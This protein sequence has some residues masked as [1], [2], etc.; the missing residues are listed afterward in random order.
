MNRKILVCFFLLIHIVFAHAQVKISG[1]VV[2]K[3]NKQPLPYV[4]VVIGLTGSGL[5]NQFT[6][7]DTEGSFMMQL[8]EKKAKDFTLFCSL[9][10]YKSFQ[11][12][13][14]GT[15]HHYAIEMV[16]VATKIKEVTVRAQKI[17]EHGDTITYNVESFRKIQDKT[18]GDVLQKMPGIE[19]ASSG[20]ISYNG[21]EINKFYIEG[22]DLL[23]GKYGI[24]TN[25][26]SPDDVGSVEILENHQPIKALQNISISS[27]TAINLRLK[28]KAKAKWVVN[29]LGSSGFSTQPDNGLWTAEMF[30]MMIKANLQNITIL[31]SNNIGKDL[32]HELTDFNTNDNSADF[33]NYIDIGKVST[34]SLNKKRVLFNHSH[35]FTT[36]RLWGLE[37]DW[38]IK[39]QVNYLNNRTSANSGSVTTYFLT[40]RNKVIEENKNFLEHD[41]ELTTL[42]SA[43]A[44]KSTFYLKNIFRSSFNWEDDNLITTGTL[45]NKQKASVPIYKL[46][47]KFNLIKRFGKHII[48]FN[49]LNQWQS[50][51]QSLSVYQEEKTIKQHTSDISFFTDEKTSY[52]FNLKPIYLSMEGNIQALFRDFRSSAVNLP[53]SLGTFI[54]ILTT[55]Y[56][57]IRLTPKIEFKQK[58]IESTLEIPF[59]YYHYSFAGHLNNK[60][61]LIANP[62]LSIKWDITPHYY[63][64]VKGSLADN[65]NNIHTLYDG[66]ILSDYRTLRT[67]INDCITNTKETLSTR[68]NYMN[69][70][71]GLFSNVI[72]TRYWNTQNYLAGQSFL[73]DYLFN[74]YSKKP[75]KQNNWTIMGTIAYNL[76]FI[77]GMTGLNVIYDKNNLSMLSMSSITPYYNKMYRI[78]WK[79]NGSLSILNWQYQMD[80][81]RN[82]LSIKNL[83][84]Q[85]NN[86][87]Q[88]TFSLVIQPSTVFNIQTAGEYYHNEVTEKH[89]KDIFLADVKCTYS[90]GKHLELA[91]T[92]SNICNY[93]KY[94]YTSYNSL[95]SITIERNIRGREFLFS[96]FFNK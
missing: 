85:K 70:F 49:S 35:L 69:P 38:E 2:D 89:Y 5:V 84:S 18:I 67:G 83:T 9:L 47:N 17:K 12:K 86:Q 32:S 11:I 26:I 19:V 91:T 65:P 73:G 54:N 33:E 78:I 87:W 64:T 6:Q 22:R 56:T 88:H 61:L 80:F 25:G 58:S 57:D 92:V 96:I 10:G 95:S 13:L 51:P 46:K 68:F 36:N 79:V 21:T 16:P 15:S 20:K 29:T 59:D 23:E 75:S 14:D 40:D 3:E 76:N 4:S 8:N 42:V 31:K 1:L 7:T 24:A 71:I 48:S 77:H 27:Q 53:D 82:I 55:N 37:N 50:R 81:G 34:S 39:A 28:S 90:I 93:K 45:A 63:I 52:G 62:S 43:E 44:N 66:L 94:S 41:N 74:Y 60:N 72:F 30:A